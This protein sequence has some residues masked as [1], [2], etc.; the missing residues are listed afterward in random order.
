MAKMESKKIFPRLLAVCLG[1][2][3]LCLSVS[4]SAGNTH[5]SLNIGVPVVAPPPVVTYSVPVV[6]GAVVPASVGVYS[7]PYV[8]EAVIV[9]SHPA[10]HFVGHRPPV[11]RGPPHRPPHHR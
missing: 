11:R 1:A 2:G 9:P 10:P 5:F 7:Y 8:T 3:A 4:A 6:P